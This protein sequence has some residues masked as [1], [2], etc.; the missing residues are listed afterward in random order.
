MPSEPQIN[1][2]SLTPNPVNINTSFM[3]S[4]EVADVDI[5]MYKRYAA[6]GALKS[7]QAINLNVEKE[8]AN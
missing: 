1:S 3:I 7:G 4:I 8:V 6:S 5:T 2:V